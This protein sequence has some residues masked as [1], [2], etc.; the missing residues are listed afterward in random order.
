M[1]IRNF[2]DTLAKLSPEVRAEAET[3]AAQMIAEMALAELRAARELS[4]EQLASLLNISQPAVAKMER[5][6][7]MYLS[8]L[9]NIVKAMGGTLELVAHFPEGDVR[10]NQFAELDAASRTSKPKRVSRHAKAATA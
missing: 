7:D 3:L 10:I 8:T 2:E 4:Q 6:A 1:K 9:R 5:Q